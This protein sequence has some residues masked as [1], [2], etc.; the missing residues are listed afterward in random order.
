MYGEDFCEDAPPKKPNVNVSSWFEDTVSDC[1]VTCNISEEEEVE[2]AC[3]DSNISKVS[4]QCKKMV[5]DL[6]RI[7]IEEPLRVILGDLIEA[8]TTTNKVQ[9]GLSSKVRARLSKDK[10]SATSYGKVASAPPPAA[11]GEPR[12]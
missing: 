8:V 5:E 1:Q 4:N 11:A 2:L 12:R 7:H 10:C 6:Q 9:E 3:L